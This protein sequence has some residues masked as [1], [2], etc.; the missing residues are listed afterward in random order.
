MFA[1]RRM[2]RGVVAVE[3]TMKSPM[4]APFPLR[5]IA[6]TSVAPCASMARTT[7]S[8]LRFTLWDHSCVHRMCP[9]VWEVGR[10][11]LVAVASTMWQLFLAILTAH[12]WVEMRALKRKRFYQ[13][14]RR[15]AKDGR[16]AASNSKRADS[17][18]V[19]VVARA[20]PT[21]PFWRERHQV[22]PISCVRGVWSFRRPRLKCTCTHT[23]VSRFCTV[24]GARF[25]FHWK[26]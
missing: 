26:P 1:R 9:H 22:I 21:L 5:S 2:C 19:Q 3:N 17:S 23:A 20:P 14:E 4:P 18:F 6:R 10:G 11:E 13:G 25:D 24:G 16:A 12:A 7:S 15:R 8:T